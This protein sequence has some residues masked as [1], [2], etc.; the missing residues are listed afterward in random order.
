MPISTIR[1][2][3]SCLLLLLLLLLHAGSMIKPGSRGP[4][5]GLTLSSVCGLHHAAVLQQVDQQY[6]LY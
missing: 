5:V 4:C 2:L 6:I 3:L 1:A